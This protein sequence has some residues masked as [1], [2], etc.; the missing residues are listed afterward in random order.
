MS[1]RRP[2]KPERLAPALVRLFEAAE[3]RGTDAQGADIRGIA[4]ALREFGHVAHW[5]LPIHGLFVPNNSQVAVIVE[6]VATR[7]LGLAQARAEFREATEIIEPFD[8]RDA[9]ETAHNRVRTVTEEAYFY[10]GLALGITM[11]TTP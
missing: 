11:M 1:P 3:Q 9:I 7:H 6:L 2:P 4:H 10:A 5:V 8:R